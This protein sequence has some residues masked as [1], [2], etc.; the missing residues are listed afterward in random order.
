MIYPRF[1]DLEKSSEFNLNM[2][3]DSSYLFGKLVS[4]EVPWN[5]SNFIVNIPTSETF[6]LHMLYIVYFPRY[7]EIPV[8]KIWNFD[9]SIQFVKLY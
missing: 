4:L 1:P 6:Q 5:F 7:Y 9:Q 8:R 3:L 2:K